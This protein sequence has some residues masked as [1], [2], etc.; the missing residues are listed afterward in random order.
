MQIQT[1]IE[2]D[3]AHRL[4][5]YDGKCANLHG[6]RWVLDVFIDGAINKETGFIA[7]FV[8]VKKFLKDKL[9]FLDHACIL[10]Y[11]DPLLG[12]YYNDP[13]NTG[14]NINNATHGYWRP[15]TDDASRIVV[16][17]VRPT[18]EHLIPM[19]WNTIAGELG[20][21]DKTLKLVKLVLA[22]TP[23]NACTLED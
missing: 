17:F 5:G 21:I 1:R 22:E 6:H 4:L 20:E 8:D 3:S 12:Y 18:C 16:T 19:I 11:G 7:D 2:F 15:I 9:D 10:Q 14:I 13:D 23:N